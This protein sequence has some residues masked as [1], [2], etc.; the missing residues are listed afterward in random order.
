MRA[1]RGLFMSVLVALVALLAWAPPAAAGS[2][3]PVSLNGFADMVVDDA[4]DHVYVSGGSGSSSV[5]V[6]DFAGNVVSTI[7]SQPG[8]AGMALD[9]S[10]STL[11]VALSDSNAIS[12]IDTTTLTELGRL[13]V[14]PAS[15]PRQ[16]ALAGGRL[17]FSHDCSA[18]S[19]RFASIAIDGS[20]LQQYSGAGYP[21]VCPLLAT[22]PA[23]PNVLVASDIGSSPP[24]IW[25]YDASTNTP[26]VS[27]TTWA[28]GSDDFEDMAVTPDGSKLIAA[29]GWPYTLQAFQM[30][31]LAGAGSFPTGAYPTSVAVTSDGAFVAAGIESASAKEILVFPATSSTA[32]R[33][34]DFGSSGTDVYEGGLAFSP[35]ASKL[36]AVAR[37]TTAGTVN[38]RVFAS[39]TVAPTTT[40][41]SLAVSASTV[42]YNRSVTLTATL[43][44][45]PG[46]T[47][48]IYATPYGGTKTLV[49]SAA[50]NTYGK[51]SATFTMK[52]KTTFVAEYVGDDAHAA[53]TSST[54]TVNVRAIATVRLSG[55]YGT[56]GKYKLYHYPKDASV[57]GTVA[58]N[59]AGYNVKFTAQR[60]SSGAWRTIATASF[61]IQSDGSAYAKLDASKGTYRTRVTFGGDAEHLGDTSPWVYLKI[62]S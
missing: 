10:A 20:G 26:T 59:H 13:S 57:K 2:T 29:A 33:G 56:S 11:Y 54:K 61:P 21:F 14:S 39:P 9:A 7:A 40:A 44:G 25:V 3:T 34:Y 24:N 16:L 31:D 35:D 22:S 4:T 49:R 37:G 53:S 48:A 50:V 1:Y 38:V 8:A 55:Y 5:V 51:L 43:S 45:A 27:V 36:F 18:G 41:T 12:K 52:R 47:V 19:S 30:S 17:W 32:L 42:D 58:P 23:D 62:T 28:G 60:Y 15:G 6:L 46:G